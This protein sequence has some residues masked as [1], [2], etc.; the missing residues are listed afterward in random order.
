M[1]PI[2]S[3]V[4]CRVSRRS[5][6]G[7]RLWFLTPDR[8]SASTQTESACSYEDEPHV[9]HTF[10]QIDVPADSETYP[11]PASMNNESV[12]MKTGP[13]SVFA[14]LFY[15]KP[16]PK[17]AVEKP[18]TLFVDVSSV[19]G[20]SNS[21]II[22]EAIEDVTIYNVRNKTD[23]LSLDRCGFEVIPVGN[24]FAAECFE[25]RKWVEDTYYPFICGLM[26]DR[27]GAADVRIYEHKVA[28]LP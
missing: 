17:W 24:Q 26:K 20:S 14:P 12:T 11:P 13:D 18:F 5:T 25:D 9:L 28:A 27:L 6:C 7:T 1:T 22:K 19:K 3:P 8:V 16:D 15:L 10:I 23:D 2:V 4:P 21:N